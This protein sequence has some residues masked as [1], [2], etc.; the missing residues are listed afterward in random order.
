MN[1]PHNP[2]N[3]STKEQG[4]AQPLGEVYIEHHQVGKLVKV[5]A[6]HVNSGLEVSIMGPAST[7]QSNLETA[8]V[9]KLRYVLSKREDKTANTSGKLYI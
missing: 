6:I 7:P 1:G 2:A 5:S 8:A 3:R 9:N 4:P